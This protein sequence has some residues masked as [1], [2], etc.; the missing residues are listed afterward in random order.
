MQQCLILEQTTYIVWT[1]HDFLYICRTST[2]N[3]KTLTVVFHAILS[4]KFEVDDETRIVIRG[5]LP[6]FGGWD[7]GGVPVKRIEKYV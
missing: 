7:D 6:V 3:E 1:T 4:D 2:N 5:D